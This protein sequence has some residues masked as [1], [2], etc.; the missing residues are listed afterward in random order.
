MVQIAAVKEAVKDSLIGHTQPEDATPMS[1][2]TKAR[3]NQNAIKDAETGEYFMGTEE[4]INAIAPSN[5]DFVSTF[6]YSLL[7]H[8]FVGCLQ[9]NMTCGGTNAQHPRPCPTQPD[10]FPQLH[11]QAIENKE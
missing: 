6:S 1:A 3:F 10:N 2:Q 8:H 5:E 4:F 7:F 9:P 11:P